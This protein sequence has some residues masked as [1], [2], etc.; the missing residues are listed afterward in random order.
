MIQ[1]G[2]PSNRTQKLITRQVFQAITNPPAVPEYLRG[3]ETVITFS[4]A[5][6]PPA[7]PRPGHAALVVEAQIGEYTLKKVF[8]RLRVSAKR[9]LIPLPP[10]MNTFFKVYSPL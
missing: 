9:M 10:S 2:R 3:S 7:V 8:M 5:D 6:H 1:K 4:R